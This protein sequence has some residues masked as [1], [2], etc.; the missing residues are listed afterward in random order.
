MDGGAA[1]TTDADN[2]L[3]GID[4]DVHP[5]VDATDTIL[6]GE[7]AR[8]SDTGGHQLEF[9]P[10]DVEAAVCPLCPKRLKSISSLWQHINI[11]HISRGEFPAVAFFRNHSRLVCSNPACHSVG[12]PQAVHPLRLQTQPRWT[13][14][15]LRGN[16][17]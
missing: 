2:H 9:D 1:S 14:Q 8:E 17:R 15:A 7:S 3:T 5:T 6:D 11:H 12:L 13:E 10:V 4:P 16:T